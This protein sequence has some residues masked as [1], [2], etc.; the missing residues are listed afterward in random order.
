MLIA[1][2]NFSCS[3][4]EQALAKEPIIRQLLEQYLTNR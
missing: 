1:T 3:E 4:A 2:G